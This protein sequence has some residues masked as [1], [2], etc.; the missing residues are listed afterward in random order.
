MVAV[1]A[2]DAGDSWSGSPSDS[3]LGKER[4]LGCPGQGQLGHTEVATL[5]SQS[6]MYPCWVS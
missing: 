6:S 1:A 4:Q 5:F 3:P 2:A